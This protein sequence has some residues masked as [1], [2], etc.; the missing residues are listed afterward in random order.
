MATNRQNMVDSCRVMGFVGVDN[1]QQTIAPV[2]LSN[3]PYYSPVK[4]P[5]LLTANAGN[6]S[7][8]SSLLQTFIILFGVLI[9]VVEIV[10]V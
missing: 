3:S 2:H 6:E 8:C 9:F 7:Q 1:A 10:Q 5:G 4:Y